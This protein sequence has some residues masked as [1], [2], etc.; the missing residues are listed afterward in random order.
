ML[1][2]EWWSLLRKPLPQPS[3]SLS[4]RGSGYLFPLIG[5]RHMPDIFQAEDT[6]PASGVYTVV[7]EN[8]HI[9]PHYVTVIYGQTFPR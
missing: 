3:S 5:D 4:N 6:V 8:M 9:P 2:F 7:H 1:P